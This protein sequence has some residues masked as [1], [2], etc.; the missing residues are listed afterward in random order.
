VTGVRRS[1]HL[2]A[3]LRSP[4]VR[5]LL[6]VRLIGQFGDGVFQASLAGAVLFNPERQAHAADIAAG[7][8]VLLL[9]YSLVGPFA[10][11]LLDRWWRQRVLVTANAVR[12]VGVLG[13]AAEIAGGVK[14]VPF[15]AGALV[16]ISIS[17]FVL[18]AL[19]AA[20]PR[21]VEEGALVTANAFTATAGTVATVL[22]GGAAIGVRDLIGSSD[23]RYGVLATAALV[24]FLLAALGARSFGRRALGPSEEERA[25][26][27]TPAQVARGLVAGARHVH[28][29]PPVEAALLTMGGHRLF[30]GI[31]TVCTLLLYRNW[32][33]DGRLLRSGLTGLAQVLAAVAVGG[34][35]AALC[36][37]FAFR[38]VGP[39]SWI[40]A[41]LVVSA[42][43]EVVLGL[44]FRKWATLIAAGLLGLASQSLK[45]TVDTVVQERVADRYRGRVFALYDMLFNLA[46]VAAAT[47]TALALPEDG[48]SAVAVVAVGGGWALLAA[49]YLTRSRRT[50]E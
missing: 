13:I 1:G 39:R 4:G 41:M 21:V 26:R 44:P 46:L 42:V 11:V 9:P 22:G 8:A 5:R 2:V 24:P 37:P 17:R 50:S 19:S 40:T 27:E 32:F 14:G 33:P 43:L 30:Y 47:I 35:A 31:W 3:I 25:G 38:R 49:G 12:G 10:G 15:Y 16:V 29:L 23:N 6:A 28:H 34:A 20:L 36:T 45:I 7:F 18:S 48:H